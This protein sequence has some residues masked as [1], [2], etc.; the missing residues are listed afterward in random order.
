MPEA[1]S[2]LRQVGEE[3][4]CDGFVKTD[5]VNIQGAGL[6]FERDSHKRLDQQIVGLNGALLSDPECSFAC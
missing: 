1:H 4:G 6:R 5:F 2:V 3:R